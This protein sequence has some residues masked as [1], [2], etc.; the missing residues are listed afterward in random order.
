MTRGLGS[1]DQN[2]NIEITHTN[3]QTD[4]SA[5]FH[6]TARREYPLAALLPL[7][8]NIDLNESTRFSPQ[9]HRDMN[10]HMLAAHQHQTTFDRQPIDITVDQSTAAA[11][12]HVGRYDC[13][14]AV[15]LCSSM[16]SNVPSPFGGM[17]KFT[18]LNM[19]GGQFGQGIRLVASD[20]QQT[21]YY[22]Q[23][24]REARQHWA[25]Y[26]QNAT[27][28]ATAASGDAPPP[29]EGSE[30]LSSSSESSPSFVIGMNKDRSNS[31]AAASLP[32]LTSATALACILRKRPSLGDSGVQRRA[33][34]TEASAEK[35]PASKVAV[36]EKGSTPLTATTATEAVTKPSRGEMLKRAV[37]EYGSTVI[38][39]HVAISLASLG[40]CYALVSR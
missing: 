23:M 31:D 19:P 4:K 32:T 20:Q 37:K 35:Q 1:R 5:G 39:F 38:V 34:S 25:T 24:R 10:G 16:Q 17:H 36:A 18:H 7:P 15:S 9:R 8:L 12:A 30:T 33:Y 26:D 22:T 14:G 13:T 28:Q 40:T 29:V 11:D 2:N 21:H 3:I 27:V 6:G